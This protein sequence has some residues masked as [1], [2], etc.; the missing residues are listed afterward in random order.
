ML[1]VLAAKSL[2]DNK[3]SDRVHSVFSVKERAYSCP[4]IVSGPPSKSSGFYRFFHIFK[5]YVESAPAE[6]HRNTGVVDADDCTD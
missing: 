1:R 4:C 5:T 3:V 2:A 6:L